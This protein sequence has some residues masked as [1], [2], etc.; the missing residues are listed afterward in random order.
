MQKHHTKNRRI[1]RSINRGR[2]AIRY[3]PITPVA[4]DVIWERFFDYEQ[5]LAELEEHLRAETTMS[6]IDI[7][8]L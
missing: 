8:S 7:D 3:V 5:R 4:S 6:A 1:S 2:E